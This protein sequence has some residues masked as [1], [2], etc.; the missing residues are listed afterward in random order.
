MEMRASMNSISKANRAFLGGA[1]ILVGVILQLAT[2]QVAL[3]KY[4][5]IPLREGW[6]LLFLETCVGAGAGLYGIYEAHSE[7]QV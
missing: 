4:K 7:V 2:G 6:P 3:S 1:V 5:S